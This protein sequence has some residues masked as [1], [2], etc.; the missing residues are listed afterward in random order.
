M[1]KEFI[2]LLFLE[3]GVGIDRLEFGIKYLKRELLEQRRK[4]L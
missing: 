2:N 1:Y 3:S 4:K